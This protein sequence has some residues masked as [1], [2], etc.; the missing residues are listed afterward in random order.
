MLV[1][2]RSHARGDSADAGATL[3]EVMVVVGM[4]GT[5]TAIATW[6]IRGWGTSSA[7]KGA[8]QQVQAVLRSTQQRA[9]TEGT[10]YCVQFGTATDSYE[11]YRYACTDPTLPKVKTAGPF[12]TG[13]GSVH[14][15]GPMFTDA[16][17]V[18]RTGVTFLPRGSA[19]PG[20]VTVVRSGSSLS[21]VVHVEGMTG[22]VSAS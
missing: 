4:I 15:S 13:S 21:Y 18:A 20:Q 6:G 22:R 14:L 9:I 10:S 19:W 11:V 12:N 17:G 8:S 2:S 3:V 7:F 1:R 5:L 16:T